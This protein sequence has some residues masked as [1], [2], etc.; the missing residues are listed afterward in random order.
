MF[1]WLT[2]YPVQ[3]MVARKPQVACPC[4]IGSHP[5]GCVERLFS[6]KLLLSFQESDRPSHLID[7]TI[8]VFILL[9]VGD[10]A[11]MLMRVRV[12]V[13]DGVR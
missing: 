5:R 2:S 1:D 13:R 9:V 12:V 10:E 7:S 3:T 8:T 6:K 11:T 4:I